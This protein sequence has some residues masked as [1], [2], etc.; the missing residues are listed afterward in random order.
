MKNSL[1]SVKFDAPLFDELFLSN[2]ILRFN[3]GEC[4]AFR[5]SNAFCN[6]KS[7]KNES[8]RENLEGSLRK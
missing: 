3:F 5:K 7:R 6:D 2:S 8:E 1:E 4:C